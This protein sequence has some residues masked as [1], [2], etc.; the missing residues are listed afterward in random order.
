MYQEYLNQLNSTLFPMSSEE[1]KELLNNDDKLDE[2]V[3][4]V[5][6]SLRTQKVRFCEENR[7]RAEQNIEKEPKIIELRGKLAEL[8]EEGRTRCNAVQ[9]LLTQIKEKTSGVSQETALALLQTAASE[10]EEQTEEIV[11]KFTSNELNVDA[12]V[13]EFLRSRRTMHL[14]KLKAEKM[15]ELIRKQAQRHSTGGPGGG[16]PAYANV[17]G[18]AGGIGSFYPPSQ[19]GV[20]YPVM[21]PMMP[22][23]PPSRPY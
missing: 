20:P 5:L 21:G 11:K 9:E 17:P 15:Q 12:F 4:E 6:E 7:N 18:T 10:S 19:M 8:T 23:P 1:L 22:M 13:E 3:D 16:V 2:K 14:R